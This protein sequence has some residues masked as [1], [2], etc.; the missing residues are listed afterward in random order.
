MA[1]STQ[2]LEAVRKGTCA[3]GVRGKTVAVLGVEKKSVL[4]LQDSRTVRK[5]A[6]LDNHICMAAAGMAAEQCPDLFDVGLT[7]DARVLI[8]KARVECQ[9]HRLSVEDAVSVE[10]ITRHIATIQ[11]KYTQ[12]GG[13]RPFGISTLIIGWD[14]DKVP[15]LYQTDPS[16]IYSAWKANAIGRSSKTVREF[17]EQ[18]YKEDMDRA[19]TIKLAIKSLLEVVQTGAKNI[20]IAVMENGVISELEPSEVEAVTAIIEAENAAEV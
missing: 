17:L 1:V 12:S 19:D 20:E 4:K 8:D 15:K 7:A 3:V 16:G 18:N 13:V 6:M 2:A 14:S 11:Q 9:S 5:I 10:Y